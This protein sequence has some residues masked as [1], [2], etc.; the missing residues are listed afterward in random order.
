MIHYLLFHFLRRFSIIAGAFIVA[1]WT[2]A[3]ATIPLFL[4]FSFT[5]FQIGLI[6][7]ISYFFATSIFILWP[8]LAD[9]KIK[10]LDEKLKNKKW[11]TIPRNW[12]QRLVR[13]IEVPTDKTVNKQ[14]VGGF[15]FKV[16]T[17]FTMGVGHL[18]LP[19]NVLVMLEP[20]TWR[21]FVLGFALYLG[22]FSRLV[23]AL[24]IWKQLTDIGGWLPWVALVLFALYIV[25]QKMKKKK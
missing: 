8:V 16:A 24:F 11:W 25:Y 9:A 3:E 1:L 20:W 5:K 13:A 23:A 12:G 15:I 19:G 21:K 22:A 6:Y 14:S 18:Y 4:R 10:E 7:G 2:G 17:F